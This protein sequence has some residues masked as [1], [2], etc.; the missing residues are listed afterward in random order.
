MYKRY[1]E[2]KLRKKWKKIIISVKLCLILMNK[3]QKKLL[4]VNQLLSHLEP[5]NVVLRLLLGQEDITK[6]VYLK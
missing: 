5:I 1:I 2:M 6:E 4:L 3:K